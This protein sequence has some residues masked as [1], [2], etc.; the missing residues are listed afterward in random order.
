MLRILAMVSGLVGAAG[1]SQFPEF[2]QQYLQRLAGKVDQLG[3]QV[4]S[5]EASALALDMTREEYLADLALSRSGAQASEKAE[6]EIALFDRLSPALERLRESNAYERLI[7]A[8]QAI[9]LDLAGRTLEDYKP[10]LPLTAEGAVF[11]AVGFFAGWGL[12]SMIWSVLSWPMRRRRRQRL[13]ALE[14]HH[15]AEHDDV[16]HDHDADDLKPTPPAGAEMTFPSPEIEYFGDAKAAVDQPVPDLSL[17]ASD[18]RN[19]E[20][21]AFSRPIILVTFPIALQPGEAYPDGWE[22]VEGGLGGPPLICSLRDT[23]ED[24]RSVGIAG[25][26]GVSTDA[27]DDQR[28]LAHLLALPYPLLSDPSLE[29]AQALNLPSFQFDGDYYYEPAVYLFGQGRVAAMMHPL[30]DPSRAGLRL[31]DQLRGRRSGAA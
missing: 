15:A 4:S 24:L 5:V 14:T 19:I 22:Q 16:E 27:T 21:R 12:W 6:G 18:G 30:R 8:H 25:V 3:E 20:L 29:L 17:P 11:S 26:F 10:A 2:S 31:V 28:D 1:L 23:M 7:R 9:D 13:V